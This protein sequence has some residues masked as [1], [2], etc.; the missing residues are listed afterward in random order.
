MKSYVIK[1]IIKASN[2]LTEDQTIICNDKWSIAQL[3]EYLSKIYPNNS[4]SYMFKYIYFI[5]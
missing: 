2:Q 5:N 1:L 3:K 4:V